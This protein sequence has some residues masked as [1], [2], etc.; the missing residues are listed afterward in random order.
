MVWFPLA[1][2]AALLWAVGGILVKKGYS[3]VTPLWYNILNNL[4]ALV[5]WLPA[6]LAL[7]GFR[8]P[9]PPWWI[10]LVILSAA[11]IY[12]VFYYSLSK[13]QVSLTGT[14]IAGYP[15]FTILLAHLFLGER[16]AGWQYGGVALILAGGVLVAMPHRV[17]PGATRDLSWVLWGALGAVSIGTGDFLSKF[18][19]NRIGPYANLFFLAILN[20][21][22][23][24]VNYLLDRGNR[25]PPDFASPSFRFCLLGILIHLV[26]ALG[27]LAAFGFGPASLISSVSSIYP[28]ILVVLAVIFLHDRISWRH[29]G[30]IGAIV[31]G[32][33][34]VGLGG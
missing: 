33:T 23:S 27:F 16:L 20:N 13:G 19:V 4:L 31:S 32:L 8:M 11:V 3:G 24:G 29:I 7:N 22:T 15:L 25:R 6:S 18:S 1:L 5:V 10:L 21:A 34:L 26:G 2:G 30:G 28:A 17:A 12:Q 9:L 14:I